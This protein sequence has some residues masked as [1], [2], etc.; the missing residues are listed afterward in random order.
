MG[1]RMD[2]HYIDTRTRM[3]LT[4]ACNGVIRLVLL[5]LN[6]RFAWLLAAWTQDRCCVLYH[7]IPTSLLFFFRVSFNTVWVRRLAGWVN[8]CLTGRKHRLR[9]R[10]SKIPLPPHYQIS[11]LRVWSNHHASFHLPLSPSLHFPSHFTNPKRG[12]STPHIRY[13]IT[14]HHLTCFPPLLSIFLS[15]SHLSR[16]DLGFNFGGRGG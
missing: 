13:L 6:F 2:S 8:E 5:T 7:T 12:I 11:P 16:L 14:L 3:R 15:V 4:L 10:C 1:Q 9:R